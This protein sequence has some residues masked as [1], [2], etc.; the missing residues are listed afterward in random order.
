MNFYLV[1]FKHHFTCTR[2]QKSDEY[3]LK[4]RRIILKRGH[5]FRHFAQIVEAGG[6]WKVSWSL[7]KVARGSILQTEI[8]PLS[9]KWRTLKRPSG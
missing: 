9:R 2:K 3:H 1:S 6:S 8:G 7:L 5:P 4:T